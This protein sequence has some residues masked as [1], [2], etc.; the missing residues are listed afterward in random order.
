MDTTFFVGEGESDDAV[1]L[2]CKDDYSSCALKQ[3]E[4]IKR[5]EDYDHVFFCDD[6]TFVVGGRL[7]KSNF[8]QYNYVGYPCDT[9]GF[10]YAHGG[11]G[12]WLNKKSIQTINNCIIHPDTIYSDRLV[13]FIL[14]EHGIA[15]KAD[16]R[17]NAGK[18]IGD[19]GF[20]NL[21]PN[22]D[23]N[24]ITSH[25]M[26]PETMRYVYKHFDMGLPAIKNDYVMTFFDVPVHI[27]QK[28]HS[29]YYGLSGKITGNF[30]MAH[31]AE[32]AA[33]KYLSSIL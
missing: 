7:L 20:C 3:L 19:K 32:L 26:P 12:F 28:G 27:M 25:F 2:N 30:S 13:G 10:S 29:W 15:L 8:K 33:F 21:T 23:N 1:S 5:Y 24:Y 6:D 14:N 31:E 22:V 17:Y 11:A 9:H 18:Y 16:F 4:M